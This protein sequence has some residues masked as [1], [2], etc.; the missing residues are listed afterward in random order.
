MQEGPDDG[1]EFIEARWCVAVRGGVSGQEEAIDETVGPDV[2][3]VFIGG[4]VML[5]PAPEGGIDLGS[6]VEVKGQQ[7]RDGVEWGGR[8]GT[9][10]MGLLRKGTWYLWA[11]VRAH[12]CR[13]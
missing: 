6:V 4:S 2:D 9:S 7:G 10:M 13:V 1:E 8:H 5:F 12:L 11:N 3:Q